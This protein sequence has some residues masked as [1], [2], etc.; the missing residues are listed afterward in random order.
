LN[1]QIWHHYVTYMTEIM[2]KFDVETRKKSDVTPHVNLHDK[3][4]VQKGQV[5]NKCNIDLF[6]T[7]M[8]LLS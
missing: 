2:L 4:K 5:S 1:K 6:G 3:I 8:L 7:I